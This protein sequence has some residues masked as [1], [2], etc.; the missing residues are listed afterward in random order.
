MTMCS[1]RTA[2]FTIAIVVLCSLAALGASGELHTAV[3]EYWHLIAQGDLNGALEYVASQSRNAFIR[4]AKPQVRS[5][6]IDEILPVEEGRSEVSVAVE[7]V[8]PGQGL[9]EWTIRESWIVEEGRWK[10]LVGDASTR[11]RSVWEGAEVKTHPGILDVLP[12][13]LRIHFISSSQAST[14]LIRNG[15]DEEVSVVDV[16]LDGSRFKVD[17]KPSVIAAGKADAVVVL[18]TGQEFAKNQE[19]KIGIVLGTTAG[20]RNFSVPV[21]YNYISRGTRALLGLTK[22]EAEKLTREAALSLRPALQIER[23]SGS[24]GT[25]ELPSTKKPTEKKPQSRFMQ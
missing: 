5:W 1:K 23:D 8:L 20:T 12:T 10:V 7:A 19:S 21:T 4:K 14:L 24:T 17:S 18:Y 11:W 13:R 16:K 15:L 22:K 9:G 25:L 2:T 6:R 3:E